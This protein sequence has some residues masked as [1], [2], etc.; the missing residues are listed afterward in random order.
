MS[1][2]EGVARGGPGHDA[3]AGH[4]AAPG[5]PGPITLIHLAVRLLVAA[6]IVP[7]AGAL[8][9]LALAA[10]GQS[11]VTDQAIARFLLIPAGAA[12]ALALGSLLLVAAV[13]DVAVMSHALRRGERRPLPALRAGLWSVLRRAP[14]LLS[15]A[16]RLV[17]RVMAVAAPSLALG[18]S[19]WRWPAV[20]ASCG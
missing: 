18:A 7:A 1:H 10:S 13:L 16:L 8:F 19:A 20:A 11:A 2:V 14:R 6:A 5:R 4:R 12:A 17:L 15:F 3:I 9:A